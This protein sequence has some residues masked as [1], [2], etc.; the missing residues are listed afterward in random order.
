[1]IKTILISLLLLSSTL[2][3]AQAG[4]LNK[5]N[6]FDFSLVGNVP[7]A[8]GSFQ[9]IEYRPSGDEMVEARDWLDYGANFNYYHAM[10]K[11]FSLGVF[12]AFKHYELSMPSSYTSL[13]AGQGSESPA[14]TTHLRFESIKYRN[15]YFGPTFEFSSKQ[16]SSGIGFSYDFSL[17]MTVSAMRNGKYGYSLNEF[18]ENGDDERWSK[19]DYYETAYNWNNVF[20]FYAQTGFKMRIPISNFMSF[21]TGFRYTVLVN[22]KPDSF[23]DNQDSDIFNS[24][25]VYYQIQRENL[26]TSSFEFG[27]TFYL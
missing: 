8:S 21:Y 3:V 25:D 16:G 23:I 13:Y 26:F 27:M 20:G 5:K 6:Y 4:F 12:A 14:D 7:I 1:M 2:V 9:N 11:R 10:S 17:G 15:I 22:S 18:S 19:T 24:E